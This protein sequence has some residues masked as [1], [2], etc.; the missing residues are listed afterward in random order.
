ML[1]GLI[2]KLWTLKGQ[3]IHNYQ[4]NLKKQSK[5]TRRTGEN[6]RYGDHTC[7]SCHN[8]R[9]SHSKKLF[10][11]LLLFP[12]LLLT[13]SVCINYKQCHYL[14]GKQTCASSCSTVPQAKS[15]LLGDQQ[16]NFKRQVISTFS[17]WS[18]VSNPGPGQPISVF[19]TEN[20]HTLHSITSRWL[21]MCY[22]RSNKTVY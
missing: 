21:C 18:S 19:K 6:H 22:C 4:L 14:I 13:Q 16:A 17:L 2:K 15:Q 12:S 1:K 11:K 3:Q 5:Q 8:S 20:M 10:S 9:H 7:F